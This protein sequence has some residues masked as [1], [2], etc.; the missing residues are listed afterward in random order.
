MLSARISP[1]EGWTL[2]GQGELPPSVLFAETELDLWPYRGRT[3][4][5]L[6]RYARASIEVGR[7]PS[8]LGREFFRSRVMSHSRGS[9]E[10]TVVFVTDIERTLDE[11]DGM[12]KQLVTMYLLEDYTIPEIA[13]LLSCCEKTAERLLHDTIDQVS[14]LLLGRRLLD[15]L[16][17]VKKAVV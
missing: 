1:K 3:V 13:R 14:R 17:E 15:R 4:G 12:E 5:L 7:L 10:D 6:R 8:L 16:P 11:L 9:F 2:M